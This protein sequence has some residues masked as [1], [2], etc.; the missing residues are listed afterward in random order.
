MI[1]RRERI[2]QL[3]DVGA[4]DRVRLSELLGR[5]GLGDLW[6]KYLGQLDE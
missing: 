6:R 5:H 1:K 3:F 2:V 4:I